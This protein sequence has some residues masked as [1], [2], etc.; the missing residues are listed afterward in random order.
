MKTIKK[1]VVALTI[2]FSSLYIAQGQNEANLSDSTGLPGDNF[3]LQGA[4]EMF[5]NSKNLEEFEK[6]LNVENNYVNNLDLNNDGKIDYVRVV[7]NAK[8]VSH[9]VVLQV[10]V[11]GSEFQDVAVIEIE[12]QSD[13]NVSVQIV[14]DEDLYGENIFYEPTD[15]KNIDLK[16]VSGPNSSVFSA[17]IWINVW[18]WPSIQYIYSPSYVVWVSPWY[19]DY[20]P[21]WWSPWYV[22]P[23]H[24]YHHHSYMYHNYYYRCYD[25]RGYNAYNAYRPHRRTSTTVVNRH[26]TSLDNYRNNPNRGGNQTHRNN[27]DNNYRKATPQEV[28]TMKSLKK[29]YKAPVRN[30][31]TNYR[32]EENNRPNTKDNR[33]Y[34]N[35]DNKKNNYQRNTNKSYERKNSSTDDRN[36][37]Y[38]SKKSTNN[39]Y[40]SR[41]SNTRRETTR[42]TNTRSSSNKRGR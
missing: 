21:R 12:K 25:R 37:S 19:W 39:N 29:S 3:S 9:A 32:N 38:N 28:E 18:F 35:D 5:K 7:E 36:N 11:N 20:Y 10:P 16:K 1:Y 8:D 24:R 42:P 33:G 26:R 22:Y 27:N 40:K 15:E 30:D 17:N 6:S 41:E 34:G 14:G 23:W 2:A 13:K 31:N 4:L